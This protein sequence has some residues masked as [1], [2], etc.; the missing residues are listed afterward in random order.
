MIMSE[1]ISIFKKTMPELV[2]RVSDWFEIDL[3]IKLFG[4]K[5][6]SFTWPPKPEKNN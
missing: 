4:V 5:V 6:F 3:T 1:E 2:K